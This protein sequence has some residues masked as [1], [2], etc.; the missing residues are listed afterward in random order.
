MLKRRWT[1]LLQALKA[2]ELAGIAI[3][4]GPNMFYMTGLFMGLSERPTFLTVH[5]EGKASLIMPVLESQKGQLVARRLED[6]G[7][8]LDF[9][10]FSYADEEGP[11]RAFEAA[12]GSSSG[13][14]ALEFR[15]LR[16]LEYSL[17]K[18]VMGDFQWVD[19]GEIMKELR[20]VKDE[21]ELRSM[22]EAAR[23]ADLGVEVARKLLAPGERARDIV[24]EIERQ[25]KLQGAQMVSMSLA[26]GANTAIPHAGTSTDLIEEGDLA[27]LDLC[28]NVDGYWS[29]ITRTYAIG[30]ISD[31]LKQIY[32]IV[33]EAQENA[34]LKAV[35][36]MIGAQV[37]ALARDVIAARGYGDYFIHRTGHGLGL[38][39]HEDPYIVES[40]RDPLPIGST[41]T[42]EPG[43]YLPGKGGVRIEDDVVLT[44]AGLECLTNYERNL[45]G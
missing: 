12:L 34:R 1:N 10:V 24:V 11:E 38:E 15:S 2:S 36:G 18:G 28:V 21:A 29:D 7:V 17:M 45:L 40:N 14:W 8:S 33:L 5:E 3:M 35:P 25:L 31:E 22:K 20:M 32:L 30:E 37:D 4:P 16:L 41:F 13:T 26:T 44:H 9:Q 42:I 39:I 19:A 6:N 27:W 23:L 43:I